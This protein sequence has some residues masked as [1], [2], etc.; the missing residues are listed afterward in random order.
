MLSV[1]FP[2]NRLGSVIV[3]FQVTYSIAV[4]ETLEELRQVFARAL[5]ASFSG[6]LIQMQLTG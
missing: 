1:L 6:E 3:N 5:N 2:Y 4:N